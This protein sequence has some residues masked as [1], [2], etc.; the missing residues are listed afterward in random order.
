MTGKGSNA[1]CGKRERENGLNWAF[2]QT[3]RTQLAI[4]MPVLRAKA[5]AL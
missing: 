3:T 2:R 1:Y 5:G 4:I